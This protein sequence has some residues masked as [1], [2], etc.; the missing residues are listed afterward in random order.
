MASNDNDPNALERAALL[1]R[2]GRHEDVIP[3]LERVLSRE[4][5]DTEA[6]CRLSLA[7]LMLGKLRRALDFADRAAA[8]APNAEWPH[9]LRCLTLTCQGRHGEAVEAGRISLRLEPEGLEPLCALI[10]A[11]VNAGEPREAR[12]FAERAV[13]LHPDSS[14]AHEFLGDVA[15]ER[16]MWSE[17]E[18]HFRRAL[19]IDAESHNAL[20]GLA[21]ALKAQGRGREALEAAEAAL[22]RAP[23]GSDARGLFAYFMRGY[24][25]GTTVAIVATA[26]AFLAFLSTR[27][28]SDDPVSRLLT[29]IFMALAAAIWIGLIMLIRRR[30]AALHPRLEKLVI[31]ER[32]ELR[33]RQSRHTLGLLSVVAWAVSGLL[34]ETMVSVDSRLA[35][36]GGAWTWFVVVP[37]SATFAALSASWVYRLWPRLLWPIVGLTWCVL[38]L[39]LVS[40]ALAAALGHPIG[41]DTDEL[42][43]LVAAGSAWG[44]LGWLLWRRQKGQ[45]AKLE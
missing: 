39:Y 38:T 2:M 17:A 13:E 25:P 6:L 44:G 10:Q 35:F 33:R 28:P 26:W 23:P 1:Q 9:R 12:E 22:R 4:A 40:V 31:R 20:L 30:R 3:V 45:R 16:S 11:L 7:F 43:E 21:H 24:L 18:Q 19:G 27:D 15:I 42:I 8:S 5:E 14:T 34:L 36:E 32:K 41:A 37:T 29:A